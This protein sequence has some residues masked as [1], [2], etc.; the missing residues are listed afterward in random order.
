MIAGGWEVGRRV[1]SLVSAKL[2]YLGGVGVTVIQGQWG[3]VGLTYTSQQRS[4]LKSTPAGKD[5]NI[6]AAAW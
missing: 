6:D 2:Y 4:M 5:V 3:A 1:C